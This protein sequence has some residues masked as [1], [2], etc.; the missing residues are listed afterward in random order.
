MNIKN[1]IHE[2]GVTAKKAS[3][4]IAIATSEQKNIFLENLAKI[5]M[6]HSDDIIKTNKKDVKIATLKNSDNAFID[7]LTFN[8]TN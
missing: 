2:V 6:N 5:I 4:K 1:Y 7:R 8:D 3:S